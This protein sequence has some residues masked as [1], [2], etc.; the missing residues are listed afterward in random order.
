MRRRKS[1]RR[2]GIPICFR[3]DAVSV[4]HSTAPVGAPPPVLIKMSPYR[5]LHPRSVAG[6]F[7]A[8]IIRLVLEVI[9]EGTGQASG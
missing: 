8:R 4:A 7:A 5:M 3:A 1:V 2:P 6:I 9:V